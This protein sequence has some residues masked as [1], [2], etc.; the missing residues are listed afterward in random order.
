M[1]EPSYLRNP[2]FMRL[3]NAVDEIYRCTAKENPYRGGIG[4]IGKTD[5][6]RKCAAALIS[7]GYLVKYGTQDAPVYKWNGKSLEEIT[8]HK[9]YQWIREYNLRF[10]DAQK[11]AENRRA[12]R[13]KKEEVAEVEMHPVIVEEKKEEPEEEAVV[14][15]LGE[16]SD[17]QLWEELK[18]RGYDIVNGKLCKILYSY[19]N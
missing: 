19:L 6:F 2:Y 4:S 16:F 1:N 3:R 13:Q 14:P 9:V 7:E 15:S 11:K 5:L 8:Y 12:K 17:T 18:L 10:Y